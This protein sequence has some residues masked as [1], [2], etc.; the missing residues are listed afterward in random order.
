M[1]RQQYHETT[2]LPSI[3]VREL[4]HLPGYKRNKSILC[5]GFYHLVM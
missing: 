2:A 1:E 4:L 5:L 3:Q